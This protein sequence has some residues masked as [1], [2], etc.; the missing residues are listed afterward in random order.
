MTDSS[1]A[2]EGCS[3]P[4]NGRRGW[5]QMHYGRWVRKGDPGEAAP[6]YSKSTASISE[7]LLKFG[8]TITSSGCW[9][10]NGSRRPTGYGVVGVGRQRLEYVHR[11]AWTLA[12]GPIPDGLFVCHRC[13]NPPCMRPDHLFLGSDLDNI[14]DMNSKKRNAFGERNG[15]AVLSN[16]DVVELRAAM[17]LGASPTALAATW[18]VTPG[19]LYA[20]RA[21]RNRPIA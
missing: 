15:H 21:G 3:M 12:E 7:R 18:G 16:A 14:A 13:D 20:I 1:C 8:W 4:P 17:A 19:H 11:L 5:C 2:V 10:W 6:R 9:E